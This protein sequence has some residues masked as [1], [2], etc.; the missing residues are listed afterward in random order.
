M[1]DGIRYN[2]IV[3]SIDNRLG[4][5]QFCGDET[6]NSDFISKQQVLAALIASTMML[7]ACN[8]SV[9]PQES[10]ISSATTDASVEVTEETP[11]EAPSQTE[12]T[13]EA[14]PEWDPQYITFGHYEQDGDDSNGL[15]PI[16]WLILTEEDDRMLIVSR[17]ILDYQP[18]NDELT[19]ITWENCT[20]RAWLNDEFINAAFDASEQEQILT[21]TNINPDNELFYGMEGGNDTEDRVFL[22]SSQEVRD[23]FPD[24][25][26]RACEPCEWYWLRSPGY[27]TDHASIVL[28]DGEIFTKGHL[29]T[30]NYFDHG[31]RP[32][33]W[34]SKDTGS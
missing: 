34:L 5:I 20:L 2:R 24:D 4:Q 7:T 13:S 21:V 1:Q 12:A 23:L 30:F 26:A 14:E 18:Y 29:V 16:E 15:E 3:A 28:H 32:A 6:M 10:S 33:L 19:E 22:L 31:V 11:S 17:N 9:V 25:E 8:A 27:P